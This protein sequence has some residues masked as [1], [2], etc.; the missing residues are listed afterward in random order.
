[1]ATLAKRE[2]LFLD[3]D[4]TKEDISYLTKIKNI[5]EEGIKQYDYNQTTSTV[6]KSGK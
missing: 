5:I 1:M 3:I 6:K 2:D 4:F